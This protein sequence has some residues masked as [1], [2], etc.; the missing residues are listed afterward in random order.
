M[1]TLK[2]LCKRGLFVCFMRRVK[3]FAKLIKLKQNSKK[4]SITLQKRYKTLLEAVQHPGV[5]GLESNN[6]YDLYKI[7]TYE[8]A[9]QFTVNGR[10][11]GAAYTQN[12]GLFNR[13]IVEGN[14]NLYFLTEHDNNNVMYGILENASHDNELSIENANNNAVRFEDIPR[15]VLLFLNSH[16]PQVPVNQEIAQDTEVEAPEEAETETPEEDDE[17]PAEFNTVPGDATTDTP[18]DELELQEFLNNLIHTPT[19]LQMILDRVDAERFRALLRQYQITIPAEHDTGIQ[20]FNPLYDYDM[21]Q[22]QTIRQAW[23]LY[24]GT[25]DYLNFVDRHYNEIL[26]MAP[27]AQNDEVIVHAEPADPTITSINT[28]RESPTTTHA[29]A[30]RRKI[31]LANGTIG[32]EDGTVLKDSSRDDQWTTA[33]IRYKKIKNHIKIT[34]V[35]SG[36]GTLEIPDTIEGLPVTELEQ[37]SFYDLAYRK[38]ILPDSIKKVMPYTFVDCS[39]RLIISIGKDTEVY[40]KS[41]I[42]EN[43]YSFLRRY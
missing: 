31:R 27:Q 21:D 36:T 7:N 32:Y 1:K 43:I 17:I 8:G 40:R 42:P 19:E 20:H 13:N 33:K 12:E 2:A 18:D 29:A 10:Q 6:S 26:D 30:P 15:E 14:Y 35:R 34:S 25:L 37:Y 28:P 23:A 39:N 41:G 5:E 16:F 24:D 22:P 4:E 11:A 3:F 9:Q 38:I